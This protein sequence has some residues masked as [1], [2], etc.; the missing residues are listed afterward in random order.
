MHV[1]RALLALVAALAATPGLENLALARD[2]R[3][4]EMPPPGEK[5]RVIID[6]DAACE[7]DDRF[8]IALAL[9][10]PERFEIEGF[11][12]AHF[13]DAGGPRGIEKS[14][15]VIKT[16][17][18]KA[19]MQGKIPVKRGSP[20]FQYSQVPP[21]SE[22]VEFIIERALAEDTGSPLWI[23]SLGACTDV[24]AAYLKRSEIAAR[25]TVFWHGRTRWPDKCWN[26]NAY[27][28]LKAVRILFKSDLPLILFD[29]GTYLRC[30]MAE[31]E[32]KIAPRGE[33]GRYLHDFR[34]TSRSYQSAAKGF[35]DLGDIAALADPSLV[36]WE[37]VEAP[38]V[39]WDMAYDRR[40][41]WGKMVRIYQIDRDRTFALFYDKLAER[42]PQ[43]EPKKRHGG[44]GPQE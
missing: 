36:Y 8:A 27:N 31:S 5:L 17:L 43:G 20:P 25:V 16:I 3:V 28:D 30:P 12:G 29:T 41:T 2:R 18:Q 7:I 22:G 39:N 32:L 44:K 34:Y 4:P 38:G 10:C 24:A 37:V 21:E 19:G 13:G 35:Y 1:P 33:L 26:F 9:L 11:V 42:Y 6:T 14:V 15:E 40:R 23:V